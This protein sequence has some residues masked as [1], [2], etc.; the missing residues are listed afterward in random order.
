MNS[1][2]LAYIGDAVYEL[3]IRNYLINKGIIKINDLQ[4]EAIKYVS[5]KSQNIFIQKMIE[6]NFLTDEEINIYKT[7]RNHKQNHKP[8]NTDIITYKNATGLEAI[9]GY[10]YINNKNDRICDIM[11]Y[12][13][14]VLC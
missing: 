5:A 1:L 10:L 13:E 11:E 12:I 6:N 2:T 14:G 8:K 7:A 9:I 4:K 3:Y